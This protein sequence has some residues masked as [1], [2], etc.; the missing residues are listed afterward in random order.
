MQSN[1][2]PKLLFNVAYHQRSESYSGTRD[3]LNGT[4]EHTFHETGSF[5]AGYHS[6]VG[7]SDHV[8]GIL[9]HARYLALG[10][11]LDLLVSIAAP[12]DRNPGV[13]AGA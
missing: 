11:R 9:A 7:D 1:A 12:V 8:P 5:V 4:M 6:V 10:K 2:F 13:G 3:L